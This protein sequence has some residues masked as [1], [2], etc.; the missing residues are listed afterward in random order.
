LDPVLK[1]G[2]AQERGGHVGWPWGLRPWN[3][4]WDFMNEA[5]VAQW[6]CAVPMAVLPGHPGLH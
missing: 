4:G 6:D 1:I 2:P 5:M 3:R